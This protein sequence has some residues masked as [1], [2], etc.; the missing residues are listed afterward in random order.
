MAFQ[1]FREKIDGVEY[2]VGYEGVA[3]AFT[4]N[5][6]NDLLSITSFHPMRESAVSDFL[7]KAD[8][9]WIMVTKLISECKIVETVYNGQRFYMRNLKYGTG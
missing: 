9:D 5:A 4:G 6:E 8:N 1:I 2:L 3:F 7:A